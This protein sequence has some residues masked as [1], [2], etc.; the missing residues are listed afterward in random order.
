MYFPQR[1]SSPPRWEGDD[2]SRDPSDGHRVQSMKLDSRAAKRKTPG[3]PEPPARL[4]E[5]GPPSGG[6]VLFDGKEWKVAE[7][8]GYRSEEGYRVQEWCC[9]SGVTTAYLLKEK[10]AERKTTR[11][12]FTREIDAD[13]VAVAGGERLAEWRQSKTDAELPQTLTYQD[14]PYRYADTTEGMH[15]ND[16]GKRV[17][18]VTWDYWD[19]G[20]AKNLAVER[21][22]DG[23][24]DC[25]LGAYI[26]PGQVTIRPAAVRP[27]FNARL[28][29]NPF[30]GAAVY[31]PISYLVPF[32]MG[33][34]FDASLAVALPVA[35]AAGWI[36]TLPTA[37]AAGIAA[38]VAATVCA[39]T[40]RY[41]PPLT[42]GLGLVALVAAPAAIAWLARN[43]GASS[44]RL[45][46]HYAAAF[47]VGAPLLG[48]GFYSYFNLAPGP[49][50]FDQLVLALGPAAIGGLAG[51]LISGLVFR[52][53]ESGAA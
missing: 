6:P 35:A 46:V 40:F 21:W 15:E 13:A 7:E 33:W 24:F 8:G 42:S 49:H 4:D 23:S 9:E 27:G 48:M 25:Y 17:R 38:L 31:L 5:A 44:P 11:W 30:L 22:P 26:E 36:F 20:H 29:A 19:A 16:S 53:G 50:T 52:N 51:F 45:A 32:F 2:L 10:D 14:S 34:P 28:R 37:T 39:A 41:F 47:A 43:G 1:R 18:K 3:R 12:F